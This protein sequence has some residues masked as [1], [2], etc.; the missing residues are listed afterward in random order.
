[1]EEVGPAK[2]ADRPNHHGREVVKIRRNGEF[3]LRHSEY[4]WTPAKGRT[5]GALRNDANE[6]CWCGS[7]TSPLL[8]PHE[9]EH[10]K[11]D[12]RAKRTARTKQATKES[13]NA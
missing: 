5:I 6:L 3:G 7:T 12:K 8:N 10:R 9:P 4:L 1:V 11:I 13:V 2:E